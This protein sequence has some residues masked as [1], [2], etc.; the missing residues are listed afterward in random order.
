M[1]L[2]HG[3]TLWRARRILAGGPD[4]DFLEP[5]DPVPSENF[6]ACLPFGPFIASGRPEQYAVLKAAA[7]RREGRDE[8]GPAIVIFDAP[9]DVLALAVDEFT[10]LSQGFVQF[11]R[12]TPINA[13]RAAWSGLPKRIIPFTGEVP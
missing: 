10:P 3:T 5:G 13:L 9:D 8:G 1:I 11:D 2:F 4:L 7:A 12:G 6:N